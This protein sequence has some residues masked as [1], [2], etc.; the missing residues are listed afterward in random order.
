MNNE[1]IKIHEK[2]Y[3][4]F[5][6]KVNYQSDFYQPFNK[7]V[8]IQKDNQEYRELSYSFMN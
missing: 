1:A 7:N 3:E 5:Y 2:F 4:K 8:L 6:E